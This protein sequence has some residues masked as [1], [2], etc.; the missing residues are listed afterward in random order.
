MNIGHPSAE[1]HDLLVRLLGAI[2]AEI[3]SGVRLT[4]FLTSDLGAPLPLHISLS[5]PLTL[6]TANKDAFLEK[7]ESTIRSHPISG[8][9]VVPG[10]LAWYKSPD[11]E[12]LFLIIRVVTSPSHTKVPPSSASEVPGAP[13]PELAALLRRCNGVGSL[14]DQPRLYQK[15][16]SDMN[17]GAAFH[18]SVAWT[19]DVPSPVDSLRSL[20]VFKEARFKEMPK[21]E[22][23]VSGVKVKIGNVVHHVPLGGRE[24]R[25]S[26]SRK[27]VSEEDGAFKG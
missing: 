18:V 7:L 22:I 5:R 1:Q 26:W 9:S 15:T 12:R 3:G 2:E 4:K 23:D 11:S 6:T 19:F 10:G 13:N 8:F 16:A 14:F 27:A 20:T 24:G 21:W 17:I 25:P